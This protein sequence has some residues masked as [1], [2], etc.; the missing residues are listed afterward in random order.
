MERNGITGPVQ[1]TITQSITSFALYGFP[2]SHSASFALLAYASAYLKTHYLAAFTCALLNNQPMGFYHP[3]TLVKDAQRHGLRVLPV[4]VTRSGWLCSIENLAGS[5]S[6]SKLALRLGFRYVRGLRSEAGRAIERERQ[7]GGFASIDDLVRRVPE[8]RR[9]ELNMLAGVGALN[10]LENRDRRGSLWEAERAIRPPGPLLEDVQALE[11]GG[12]VS[13][14]APMTVHER[15][16]AD[17]FGTGL[18]DG[19]H[20]MAY[21]RAELRARG[22]TPSNALA[23]LPN[24]RPVRVAGTVIRRQRP[25]TAR[26]FVFLSLEDETGIANVIITPDVFAAHKAVIV[27]APYLLVEGTLQNQDGAVSIKADRLEALPPKGPEID[28]RD[29]H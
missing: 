20:S 7:R 3:S 4:D 23:V 28:S 8:L 13:P 26:G 17:Y 10:A 9:D 12:T 19:K 16:H 6:E 29:F 27:G 22:V 21:R 11:N 15:L 5:S 18:T 14:L 1:D 24:N 25:G 2:E